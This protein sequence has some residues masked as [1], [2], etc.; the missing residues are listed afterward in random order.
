[1]SFALLSTAAL[2]SGVIAIA[3]GLWLAQRLRVQHRDVEVVTTLFWQAALEET[4]ARV[5]VR[6]FRHWKAWALLVLIATLLWLLVASP[7]THSLDGTRHVILVDGGV[8]DATQRDQDLELAIEFA[9]TLPTGDREIV[10]VGTQLQTLLRPNESPELARMRFDT[11]PDVAPRTIDWAIEAL[12][13]RATV[14]SPLKIHLVGEVAVDSTRLDKSLRRSES[15]AS[16]ICQVL[17]IQRE[18]P[19][20]TIRLATL[21]VAE[22]IEGWDRVDVWIALDGQAV[23]R[24][25]VDTP[26]LETTQ[27]ITVSENGNPIDRPLRLRPDGIYELRGREA[28]G[29]TLEVSL[30]GRNVGA[31]T[32][33]DRS[34][35]RVQIEAGSPLAIRQL[36][37]LDP[38]CELVDADGEVTIGASESCNFRLADD[39][40]PAFRI[41]TDADDPQTALNELVDRLAL[42]QIDATR[43]AEETGRVVD[44]TVVGGQQ[45]SIE[46]WRRLFTG[47]FDFQESRA[48]P[49]LI[50][51]SVRW[52]AGR[53]PLIPWAELG[54]RLPTSPPSF[55]RGI[56][57][58][59]VSSDGRAL[60]TTLLATS[61]AS[62]ADVLPSKNRSWPL[63]THPMT[64]IGLAVSLLLAGEWMLYQKGLIP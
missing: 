48:C 64:W 5:F 13:S 6:R 38:A 34:R 27:N 52:L 59:T 30:D 36:I 31:I 3:A 46:L 28:D 56:G 26:P 49:I 51:R 24:Q 50:S 8:E 23:E 14:D 20:P 17:R 37:A 44:V 53:P 43:I 4:R 32:L 54:D 45:R 9:K 35:I 57:P 29:S 41:S 21:G 16:P 61:V 7:Q 10:A 62:A 25:A 12:S 58:Q 47:E 39:S 42:K 33:P 19:E 1:M 2:L 60:K 63:G 22:S 18:G 40:G 11:P 55:D 15:Q